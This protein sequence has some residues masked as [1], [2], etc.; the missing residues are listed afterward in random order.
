MNRPP[1][2]GPNAGT[3]TGVNAHR[4]NW[5]PTCEQC[6]VFHNT[7]QRVRRAAGQPQAQARAAAA[8]RN[9]AIKRLIAR[10]TAEFADLLTTARQLL[11]TTDHR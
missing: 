5:E 9:W 3:H 1:T 8:H 2:C 10:H 7:Y 11:P 6:R 4:R